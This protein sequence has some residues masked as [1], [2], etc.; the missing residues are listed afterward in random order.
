M[1]N[2]GA[3]DG[4]CCSLIAAALENDTAL[5]ANIEAWTASKN[6]WKRRAAA[7]SLVKAARR[8]RHLDAARRVVA[9]LQDDPEP[10]VRTAARWLAPVF[11]Q[12]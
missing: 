7:A 6:C 11:H 8:G 5:A 1:T 2:W 3:C 10:I 12:R 9:A 4:I